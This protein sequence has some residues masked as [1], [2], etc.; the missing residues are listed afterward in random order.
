V[1]RQ[2]L[3]DAGIFEPGVTD[4]D[5]GQ[6]VLR[7]QGGQPARLA[8]LVGG[9]PLRLHVD[10][11]DDVVTLGIGA[12][13]GRQIGTPE[14]RVVAI[15]KVGKRRVDSQGCGVPGGSQKC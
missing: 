2:H 8:D 5:G 1:P 14:R 6:A 12:E 11:G 15:A 4:R 13:V 7:A 10:G 3:L 9:I